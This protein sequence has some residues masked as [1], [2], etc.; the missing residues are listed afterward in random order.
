MTSRRARIYDAI[1]LLTAIIVI[2]LDQWTKT[3]VASNLGPPDLGP[4]VPLIGPYLT[5]YYIRNQGAA[6]NMFDTNGPILVVLIAVAVAVIGYLYLRM[7]NTGT[8][9]YKLIFGLIIGGAAGNLFDRFLHG[10]VIDFIWFR[11]PQIGFNFAIF[12]LADASISVG[13]VLLFITLLFGGMRSRGAE[14]EVSPPIME[15]E[16]R[17]AS[18][19]E[20]DAQS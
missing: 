4:Q 5:L 17:T 7:L 12:N 10:S 11:I 13:V 9:L 20:N 16:L 14:N 3:L 6:F 8:W 1:A 2:S 19:Q 18:S 15:K